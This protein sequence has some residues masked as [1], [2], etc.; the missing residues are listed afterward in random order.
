MTQFALWPSFDE[1]RM[2]SSELLCDIYVMRDIQDRM[3]KE[4]AVRSQL[5]LLVAARCQKVVRSLL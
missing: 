1:I 2:F 4:K 3:W 5:Q